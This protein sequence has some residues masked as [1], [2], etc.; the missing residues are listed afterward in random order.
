[1]SKT[2]LKGLLWTEGVWLEST[3]THCQIASDRVRE[4]DPVTY[5]HSL[6]SSLNVNSLLLF[7]EPGIHKVVSPWNWIINSLTPSALHD[8]MMWN[9]DN[10][11]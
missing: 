3:P 9:T 11:K 6:S 7:G 10:Q 8:V 1:M 4:R 2:E 5:C